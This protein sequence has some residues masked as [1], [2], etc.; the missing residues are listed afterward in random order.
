MVKKK[1]SV[2]AAIRVLR[3]HNIEFAEHYYPY[4]EKGGT[5]YG[6]EVLGVVEHALVK[7]LI[8][9]DDKQAP[10]IVLMHGDCQV[11]TKT[12]ARSIGVKTVNPCEPKIADK[13]SGYQI[14][15][16]SPFG[17][18]RAMPVYMEASILALPLMYINGGRR[19]LLLSVKP[20]DA[21][22]VLQPTLVSVAIES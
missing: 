8:M 21:Q 11:S 20:A 6:A 16:T 4:Q 15:G 10:L 3:E 19:G 1:T 9:E 18:R 2:T 13:H 7:T 12:L 5:A 14:G 17:T 22:S